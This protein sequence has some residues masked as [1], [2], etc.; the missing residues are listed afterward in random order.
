[1]TNKPQTPAAAASKIATWLEENGHLRDKEGSLFDVAS[2]REKE[3]PPAVAE[4]AI[5]KRKS[6]T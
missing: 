1:M 4:A 3:M 5:A 6:E 2:P